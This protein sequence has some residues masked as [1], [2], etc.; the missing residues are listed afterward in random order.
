MHLYYEELGL[1][2]TSMAPEVMREPLR[3]IFEHAGK[4]GD[5]GGSLP[6]QRCGKG[7]L[8][9]VL[10]PSLPYLGEGPPV[11]MMACPTKACI[12][13]RYPQVLGT[14]K[15]LTKLGLAPTSTEP[16]C[17]EMT[18]EQLERAEDV[19][20]SIEPHQRG[21]HDEEDVAALQALLK[22]YKLL[23]AIADATEAYLK[24]RG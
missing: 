24:E 11:L 3:L 7:T 19:I 14:E 12:M 17:S 21:W 20:D 5:V 13:W 1:A 16:E 2:I 9:W 15:E 22:D 4:T 8:Y 10:D 6:C 18:K 23:K